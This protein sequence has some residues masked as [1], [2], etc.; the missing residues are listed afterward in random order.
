MVMARG[1]ECTT[2]TTDTKS[3][4]CRALRYGLL[5]IPQ[6]FA[7]ADADFNRAITDRFSKPHQTGSSC[8]MAM[9]RVDHAA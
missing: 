4:I 5:N 2:S 6:L 8:S 1:N 7:S 9:G 3:T